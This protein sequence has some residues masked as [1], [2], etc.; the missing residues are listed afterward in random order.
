MLTTSYTQMLKNIGYSQH[1]ANYLYAQHLSNGTLD[2][3]AGYIEKK[4]QEYICPAKNSLYA[5]IDQTAINGTVDMRHT[6][7]TDSSD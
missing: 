2:I 4:Y 1:G 5:G 6:A 7:R 3:L